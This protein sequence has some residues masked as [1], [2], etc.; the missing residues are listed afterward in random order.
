MGVG[1]LFPRSA[2]LL[3]RLF[4]GLVFI[5]ASAEKIVRPE[6]FAAVVLNYR[7]LPE[8]LVNPAALLLPWTEAVVGLALLAGVLL[9]GAALVAA[10]LMGVFFSALLFNVARGLD[11]HC[12]CFTLEVTGEP[13]TWWYLLRDS[14]L[15]ALSVYVLARALRGSPASSR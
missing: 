10:G 9:P 1:A 7:I 13:L 5:A 12:G 4:L 2:L 8:F 11:I 15:L 14:G 6:A 3:A